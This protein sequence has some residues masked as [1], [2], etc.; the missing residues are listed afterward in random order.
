MGPISDPAAFS[1]VWRAALGVLTTVVLGCLTRA[2]AGV[3]REPAVTFRTSEGSVAPMR[4][5]NIDLVF[6]GVERDALDPPRLF[7]GQEF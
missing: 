3:K 6:V 5:P 1:I 7:Q 2:S 4:E